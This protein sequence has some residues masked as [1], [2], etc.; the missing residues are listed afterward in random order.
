MRQLFLIISLLIAAGRLEAQTI[1]KNDVPS[2][3]VALNERLTTIP[4][5]AEY[6]GYK[7]LCHQDKKNLS[8]E[9]YSPKPDNAELKLVTTEGSEIYTIHKGVIR[10]GKNVFTLPSKKISPGIYYVVSKL[11]DGKQFADRV[12]IAK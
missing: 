9:V 12:V 8:F 4:N 1:A 7:V 2:K 6:S 5:V 11:T 10:I 3:E